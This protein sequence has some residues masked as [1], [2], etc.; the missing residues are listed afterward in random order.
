MK[1]RNV[2]SSILGDQTKTQTAPERETNGDPA[3]SAAAEFDLDDL[4]DYEPVPPRRVVS[5]TIQYRQIGRGRPLPYI[6][7]EDS[8]E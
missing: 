6:L 5:I 3:D 4:V 7:D 8:K 2:D 1:S